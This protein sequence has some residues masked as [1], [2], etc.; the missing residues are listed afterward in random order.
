MI[1]PKNRQCGRKS[2][3]DSETDARIGLIEHHGRC[4]EM[5]VY[6]CPHCEFWHVGHAIRETA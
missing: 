3:Y 1:F 6:L 5:G 2:R 4:S